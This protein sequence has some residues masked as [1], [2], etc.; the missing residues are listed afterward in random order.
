MIKHG[1]YFTVLQLQSFMFVANSTVVLMYVA[2]FLHIYLIIKLKNQGNLF[3][4]TKHFHRNKME[5]FKF[6]VSHRI[7]IVFLFLDLLQTFKY[8][9]KISKY[10]KAENFL[11]LTGSYCLFQALM[12]LTLFLVLLPTWFTQ[13]TIYFAQLLLSWKKL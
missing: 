4:F 7:C 5:I 3:M 13:R 2:H 10:L 12:L 11:M 9:L 6:S 1:C 8:V